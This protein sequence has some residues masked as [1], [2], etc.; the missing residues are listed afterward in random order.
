M[1]NIGQ[2]DNLLTGGGVAMPKYDNGSLV[3]SQYPC[4]YTL[5]DTHRRPQNIPLGYFGESERAY[6]VQGYDNSK[7]EESY[8][9]DTQQKRAGEFSDR[10]LLIIM[11]LLLIALV[12]CTCISF[13][14]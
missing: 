11:I 6:D 10:T 5:P 13:H 12:V 2:A 14:F 3:R 1:Y 9:E 7:I 8:V 4:N